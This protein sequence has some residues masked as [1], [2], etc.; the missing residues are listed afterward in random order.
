MVNHDIRRQRIKTASQYLL[1][2]FFAILSALVYQIF[3]S[4][5]RFAP[6][7]LIG[8]ATIV[9]HVFGFEVGL[10][11][12]IV[13]LPMLAIAFFVLG[14]TYSL[15]TLTFTLVFSAALLLVGR[16]SLDPII[17]RASD[18][19][20]AILAAIAGGLFDG[21]IYSFVVKMGGS[22]GGTDVAASFINHK[23]PEFDT[24]WIIFAL[25]VAV[26]ALSFFVY[27]MEYRPVI[28]CAIYVF[29]NGKVSDSILKGARKAAKFEVITTHPEELSQELMHTLHHGCTVISVKGMYTGTDKF[30]V[31]CVVNPRQVTDF[32]QII[33]KYD[34]TFAFIST[35]NGTVG[36]FVRVK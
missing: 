15:R 4:E 26:A 19:G 16:I 33:R 6:S 14:R 27:D 36:D 25:N 23:Y 3:V 1:V 34:S 28:L 9:Q 30:L 11:S 2:V 21:A 12:L 13:N 17:Y 20:E 29:V 18:T 22:T 5:N 24:V 10:L 8:F 32:E 31:V 35:V 7:G